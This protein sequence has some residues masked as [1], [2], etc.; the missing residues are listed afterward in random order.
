MLGS[1]QPLGSSVV[2]AEEGR[3]NYAEKG[4]NPYVK[5]V[6]PYLLYW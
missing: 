5:G 1:F 4:G 3:E 2:P 6:G